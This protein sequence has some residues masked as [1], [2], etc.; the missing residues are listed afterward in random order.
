MAVTE[1]AQGSAERS[2]CPVGINQKIH[3]GGVRETTGES[4]R[5]CKVLRDERSDLIVRLTGSRSSSKNELVCRITRTLV[6]LVHVIRPSPSLR[7]GDVGVEN[8]GGYTLAIEIG[9]FQ[10]LGVIDVHKLVPC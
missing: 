3:R 5:R 8:M 6:G 2:F 10:R 7:H 9:G 1:I 4:T